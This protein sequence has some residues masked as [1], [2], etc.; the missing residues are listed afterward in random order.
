VLA[1]E[2]TADLRGKRALVQF[3]GTSIIPTDAL[4]LCPNLTYNTVNNVAVATRCENKPSA[5]SESMTKWL[6]TVARLACIVYL[7]HEWN[8]TFSHP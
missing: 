5:T 6:T 1:L 7:N 2:R 4:L 3:G 8:A